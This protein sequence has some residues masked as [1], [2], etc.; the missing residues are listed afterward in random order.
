MTEN[1]LTQQRLKQLL[2]YD[3]ETGVFTRIGVVRKLSRGHIGE[4]AGTFHSPNGY[5]RIGVNYKYYRAHRLA[6]LYVTGEWPKHQIDH[7]NGIKYDNRWCNLRLATSSQNKYNCKIRQDNKS[8]YKGVHY[9]EGKWIANC[10][11]NKKQYYLG[12]YDTPLEA[13]L[14][15]ENFAKEHHQEFY[16]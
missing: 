10:T 15:R 5:I 14:I 13:H 3:H 4:V 6:W 11:V 16:K 8:G 9:Q 12:I 7:I 1:I 2:K